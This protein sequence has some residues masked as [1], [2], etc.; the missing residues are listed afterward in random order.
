AAHGRLFVDHERIIPGTAESVPPEDRVTPE[1]GVAPENCVTPQDRVAPE[2]GVAPQN[3][4]SPD[5]AAGLDCGGISDYRRACLHGAKGMREGVG[6]ANRS[7][8][9]EIAIPLLE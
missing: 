5:A 8:R 4:F 7:L 2:N 6:H 3:G 9:I 1:N